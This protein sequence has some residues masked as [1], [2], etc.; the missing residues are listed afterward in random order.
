MLH[1]SFL[2]DGGLVPL[3]LRGSPES[4][5]TQC[6]VIP[7][8]PESKRLVKLPSATIKLQTLAEVSIPSFQTSDQ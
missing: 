7:G 8:A 5:M 1:G 6:G 2:A 4:G 3:V